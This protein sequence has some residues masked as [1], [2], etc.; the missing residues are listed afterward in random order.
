MTARTLRAAVTLLILLALWGC[1]P[2][3]P[4]YVAPEVTIGRPSFARAVEAHTLSGLVADNRV[5][6]LLNGDEIF[7]AMLSAI[8]GARHSI[9]LANYVYE[10]GAIAQ[11]IAEALAGRC[12]DGVAVNILVDAV[13]STA[14]PSEAREVLDRSGCHLVRFHPLNPLNARR[15]NHRNHRRSLVVDGRVAFT[16]GTGIGEKWT[17]DGR[18]EGHWRQTDVKLEG[19]IV[20][21]IQA[22]FAETWREE[23]SVLLGGDAYFPQPQPRGSVQAQSVKSSPGGGS[24][25]AYTLFLLAIEGARSSIV[26]TTPYFVPDEGIA[27]ALLK[28]VARG[29]RV[30]VLVAGEADTFLDRTM[31]K[32]SQQAFGRALAGGIKIYEYKGAMLHAKTLSVD[33]TWASIGSANMDNRSFALNHELNVVFND[34]SIAKRLEEIFRDD[35]AF[36]REVTHEAWRR[37]GLNRMF[38]LIVLP[39]RD[40][41]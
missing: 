21:Y 5:E 12:R 6:L 38:E 1:A 16:G 11:E 14:M 23:T 41:L 35:L 26:L 20:R 34:A 4:A 40:V 7:P 33:S 27:T 29:V 36:A 25:K 22:A 8:R 2:A 31:R 3:R 19:P 15:L 18:H 24:A 32:A 37:R 9:T 17:G 30:S 39:M 28:A 13:G 10:K